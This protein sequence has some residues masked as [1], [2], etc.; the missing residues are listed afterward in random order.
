VTGNGLDE[1]R[2]MDLRGRLVRRS[3]VV[4]GVSRLDLSGLGGGLFVARTATEALTLQ[5]LR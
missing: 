1:I 4:A 2:L 5:T 3:Q